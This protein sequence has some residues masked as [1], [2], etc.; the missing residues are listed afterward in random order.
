MHLGA[1]LF[2][3]L[4]RLDDVADLDVVVVAERQTA[5][6][7]LADLGGVLFE[8]L[9]RGDGDVLGH[10][11]PVAQQPG[12]GVAPEETRPD[13]A[14]GDVADLGRT[15]HLA[16][17]RGAQ[18]GL[19]VLRLEHAL[20]GRLDLLDGLVDN[21][22]VPDLHGLAVGV[23]PDL[24]LGPHVEP[25][26]DRVRRAGQV[27]IVLGDA[28]DTTV[29]DLQLELVGD[30]DL[31][32]SVF[33]RLHR[34]GDIAL[35]DEGERGPL[36]FLDAVQQVFQGHPTTTVG[37]LGSPV[38]GL[39]LLGDLPGGAVLAYG[40]ERV[41]GPGYRGQAEHLDGAGRARLG[42]RLAVLVEHGADPAVGVAG[43][44]RVTDPQGALVHQDRGHRTATAVQVRLDRDA[45]GVAVDRRPQVERGVR[46]QQDTLQEPVD[47]QVALG[48]DVDEHRV[49][50]VLLGHQP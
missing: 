19:L 26:D 31:D 27:D 11:R 28:T 9:E 41:A 5:L 15:E 39:A 14:A 8:P 10:H 4:V 2:P 21:R 40:E 30:L 38:P 17:L 34:T 22:V 47:V 12:L 46:G 1:G 45:L 36:A 16:D 6:E 44:D 32:E 50:A 3:H 33:E 49:A 48:G 20:E 29:D 43:H 23:L 25:D 13:D 37:D 18:L 42:Y 35:E 7:A 24:A